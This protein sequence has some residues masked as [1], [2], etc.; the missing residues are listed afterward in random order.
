MANV[1]ADA[2]DKRAADLLASADRRT[3]VAYEFAAAELR[4]WAAMMRDANQLGN[5]P[6][7]AMAWLFGS[8]P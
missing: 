1:W 4:E 3:A 6:E 5:T 8:R 2:L 7:D